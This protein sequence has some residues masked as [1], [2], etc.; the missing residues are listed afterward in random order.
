MKESI[1]RTLVPV[2]YALLLKAG[3]GEWLGLDDA[4]LQNA[5]ALLGAG[6]LYVVLRVGERARPWLGWLLGYAS[7]PSYAAKPAAAE[8]AYYSRSTRAELAKVEELMKQRN[9]AISDA[10]RAAGDPAFP[11]DED[12]D[13]TDDDKEV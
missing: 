9:Q 8:I 10:G 13:A 1:L 5:A 7:P 3:I 6:L 12:V 11:S 2:I 4:I